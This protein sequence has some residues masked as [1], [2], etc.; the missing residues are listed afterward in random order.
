MS[1]GKKKLKPGLAENVVVHIADINY[2]WV[3]T[4]FNFTLLIKLSHL[5]K[6]RKSDPTLNLR[7]KIQIHSRLKE[8]QILA[9]KSK[10][11]F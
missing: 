1:K 9:E 7:L 4:I 8:R 10:V 3:H 11:S 6:L 5:I 2:K